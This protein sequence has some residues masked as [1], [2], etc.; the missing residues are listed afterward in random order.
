MREK[1]SGRGKRLLRIAAALLPTLAAVCALY[2]ASFYRA[3]PEALA[4]LQTP[5][6]G[7]TITR[8]ERR[9]DFAPEVPEAGLIFYP[10]G[11]VQMEA[12]APLMA[13]LAQRGILCVLLRMPGNLAV[14]DANA[15]DGVREDYPEIR[16]W[17][18]AGHSLGGTIAARYAA[19]HPGAFAGLILLA[20]YPVDDLSDLELQ[21]LTI[22][23]SED[24][25]LRRS[26]LAAGR[27][28]LPDGAAEEILPGGCHAFFG[29]YGAQRGDGVPR[30]TNEQ[31]MDETAEAVAAFCLD[32]AAEAAA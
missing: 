1:R 25:V 3:A 10:G 2:L 11:K 29:C 23:G 4:V 19:K 17:V 30:I 15:A 28:L 24:G 13:R 5:L 14:L 21:A 20:A 7:V 31:Q 9:I 6:A 32:E 22:Y 8:T 26:R 18:L 16:R 27:A 12:Y